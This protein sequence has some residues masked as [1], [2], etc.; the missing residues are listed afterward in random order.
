MQYRLLALAAT[1]RSVDALHGPVGRLPAMGYNTFNAFAAD[2]DAELVARQAKVMQERGLV[3]AG[4]TIMLLDDFYALKER[5]ASGHMVADPDKFPDGIP[6]FSDEIQSFGMRLAAYGDNGYQ[7]CGGHPGSYGHELQDL[8]TWYSWGMTYLKYDNCCKG[9]VSL[10]PSHTTDQRQTPRRTTSRRRTNSVGT[11]GWQTQSPNLPRRRTSPSSTPYAIGD[12]SSL[13]SGGEGWL[14][15]GAP[16]AISS[17]PGCHWL[18]SSTPPLFS[19]GLQITMATT[20]S[21]FSKLA[22]SGKEVLRAI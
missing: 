1:F 14:S 4:Y 15:P 12:G 7:T 3:E 10:Q 13:G 2:Y 9:P 6:A 17:L 5:N 20:T 11:L 18:P 21:T 19:T 8:E 22:T 16:M